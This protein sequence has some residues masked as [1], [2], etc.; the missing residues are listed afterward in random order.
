MNGDD[1]DKKDVEE[2]P[3]KVVIKGNTDPY[4]EVEVY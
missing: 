2:E 4:I 1:V 3:K